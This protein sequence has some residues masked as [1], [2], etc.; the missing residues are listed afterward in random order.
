[1][2]CCWWYDED[3]DDGD[4]DDFLY[5][6][7]NCD[8]YYH[9]KYRIY[10]TIKRSHFCTLLYEYILRGFIFEDCK[11]STIFYINLFSLAGLMLL[12]L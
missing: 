11:E 12:F 8:V 3:E 2:C 10:L 1:L 9:K 5:D 7:N 4:N 6:D